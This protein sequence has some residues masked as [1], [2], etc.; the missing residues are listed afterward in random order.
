[1]FVENNWEKK[2]WLKQ[3]EP[4]VY[5]AA[6]DTTFAL[7][8][9][10]T[11]GDIW[12]QNAL[13]TGGNYVARHLPWYENSSNITDEDNYYLNNMKKGASHWIVKD[14]KS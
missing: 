13:R 9:P 1:M 3:I 12:V 4:D 10:Y 14:T 7:Y 2:H 8:K 5:D 11:R 6:L